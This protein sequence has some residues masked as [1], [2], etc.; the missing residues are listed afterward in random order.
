MGR[1]EPLRA[2]PTF[3]LW[4]RRLRPHSRLRLRTLAILV[5]LFALAFAAEAA[6]R[7][8]QWLRERASSSLAREMAFADMEREALDRRKRLERFLGRRRG[9]AESFRRGLAEAEAKT[10]SAPRDERAAWELLRATSVRGLREAEADLARWAP[11]VPKAE[12]RAAWAAALRAKYRR[13]AEAPQEPV[14]PD[15]PD[16]D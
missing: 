2:F 1:F 7:R 10:A 12:A 9:H 14:A 13:A 4:G 16:P 15:P 3:S 11:E 6:R 5:V 8:M